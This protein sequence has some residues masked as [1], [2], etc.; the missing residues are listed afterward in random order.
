MPRLALYL[1]VVAAAVIAAP[2][3]LADGGPLLVAQ[4]GSGVA[5][6]S[7]PG[8]HYI[9]VDAGKGGTLLEVVDA[10]H[11]GVFGWQRFDGSWGTPTIGIASIGAGLSHDG[12]TLVLASTAG[13][14]ASPSRFLVVDARLLRAERTI[15]LKGSFSFDALSPDGSRLYLIEYTH[16]RSGDLSHYLVREYDLRTSQLLPGRIADRSEHETSM[17]GSPVTRTASADGR[18]VYT[19]YQKPSGGSFIHA[20]D[21][22]RGVAYCIDLPQNQ[23]LFTVVL[24]LRNGGRTLVAQNR[25]RPWLDVAVG[26]WRVSSPGEREGLP[27]AWIGAG[28]G[29]GVMLL[30]AA[31]LLLR[32]RR[33]EEVEHHPRQELGLA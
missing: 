9:A 13:P 33:G 12:R 6:P 15:T 31:A 22:V 26:T 11:G 20:L 7:R 24:S 16:A 25:G 32:R 2:T 17:A 5:N 3:A 14:Y 30:V 8:L 28:I 29:A 27:W 1:V 18:W 19:L 10:R 4:G 21:T 23:D